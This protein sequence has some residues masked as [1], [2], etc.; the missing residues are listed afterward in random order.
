[1]G[2]VI[3]RQIMLVCGAGGQYAKGLVALV[4]A[5]THYGYSTRTSFGVG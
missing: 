5:H 4:P 1:M 2:K 3:D